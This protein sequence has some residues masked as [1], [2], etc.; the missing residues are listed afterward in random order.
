MSE[1]V[2]L[3]G[4]LVPRTRAAISPL[5]YGFLYGMALFETMRAYGDKVFRM[6]EHLRRLAHSA[7]ELG[8]RVNMDELHKAVAAT[9]Q[10]NSLGDARVRLTVSAG[11]GEMTPDPATCKKPTVLVMATNYKP[12]AAEV[13][14]RGFKA[15]LSSFRRNSRSLLSRVKSANYLESLLARQ[16]A[17]KAGA[18]EAVCLNERGLVAEASMCNIFLVSGGVLRTP[19]LDR[20]ILPGITRAAVLELASGM[21]IPTTEGD[22]K[23]EE[24]IVAEE[25]FLTSS[26]IEVMP[27]T[28]VDNKT[29]GT[30]RP[31]VISRKLMAAYTKLVAS[32]LDFQ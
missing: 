3:N 25:A 7:E 17:R 18:D 20:G 6:H 9:I 26:L 23:L 28:T 24:L 15:V 8:I 16:E 11:E 32:E 13:Y 29:I 19:G 10:A 5:D 31:G 14:T 4:S 30:G 22:I 27:L 12:Y 21:G 1:L 2:Y